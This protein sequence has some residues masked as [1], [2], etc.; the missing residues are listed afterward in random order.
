MVAKIIGVMAGFVLMTSG[1]HAGLPVE[2]TFLGG[3]IMIAGFMA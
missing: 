3:A 1:I 2:T